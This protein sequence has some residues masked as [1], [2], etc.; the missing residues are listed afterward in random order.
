MLAS[1]VWTPDLDRHRRETISKIEQRGLPAPT[2]LVWGANDPSAPLQLAYTLFSLICK[3]TRVA[4]LHVFNRA[5]HYVFREQP[6]A[7][8]SLLW[9][10]CRG[11]SLK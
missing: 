5:G 10:F 11:T 3:K 7:F 6:K 8:D 9:S 2:L 1:T 4:E